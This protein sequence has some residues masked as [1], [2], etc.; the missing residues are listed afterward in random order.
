M[1]SINWADF[2]NMGMVVMLSMH[3]VVYGYLSFKKNFNS[4]HNGIAAASAVAN[5]SRKN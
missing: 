2:N 3:A 4:N 5:D 1:D